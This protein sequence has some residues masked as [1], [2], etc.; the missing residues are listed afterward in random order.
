MHEGTKLI[1]RVHKI[2]QRVIFLF[3]RRHCCTSRKFCMETFLHGLNCFYLFFNFCINFFF[4][5]FIV[6]P[7]LK[8]R[9]VTLFFFHFY[10]NILLHFVLIF[11]V[12]FTL[13]Q[14]FNLCKIVFVHFFPH[15]NLAWCNLVT[16]CNFVF[17][18]F[19]PVPINLTLLFHTITITIHKNS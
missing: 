18:Q 15:A 3:A 10:K 1:A 12:I 17:V 14:K 11:S 5:L 19:R 13:V 7:N 2:A 4:F 9:S 6:T 16:S 8:P